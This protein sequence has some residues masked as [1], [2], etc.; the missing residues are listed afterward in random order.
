MGEDWYANKGNGSLFV[1]D[2]VQ[3]MDCE[4]AYS[5][6]MMLLVAAPM[7]TLLA[8]RTNLMSITGHSLT[9]PTETP[10]PS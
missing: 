7:E 5:A 1:G 6:L 2:E 10:A 4:T 9:L 8:K 3:M